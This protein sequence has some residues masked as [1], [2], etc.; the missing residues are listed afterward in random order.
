MLLSFAVFC[1]IVVVL[2]WGIQYFLFHSPVPM[3]ATLDVA[4]GTATVIGSDLVQQAERGSRDISDGGVVTTDP[5]SQASISVIDFQ[6]SNQ[7]IATITVKNGS[8]L[9]LEQDS[10]PRFD[11]SRDPYWIDMDQAYGSFDVYVPENLDRPILISLETTLGAS[12]RLTASGRYTIVAAGNQV[13]VVNYSGSALLIAP[14]LHNQLIAA[15]QT[16]SIQSGTAANQFTLVPASTNPLGDSGFAPSNVLDMNTPASSDGQVWRCFS[17]VADPNEAAGTFGVTDV[18]GRPAV[19]LF[20]DSGAVSHGATTC[21]QG[22][23][24]SS[25][26]LDVSNYSTIT[27]RATFKIQSQSLST[28]GTLGSECP[29]ELAMD[30]VPVN[31]GQPTTWYH[32]FYAFADPTVAFP[33][34]CQSC[35]E[36]HEQINP[37][38]WYTYES[39]NLKTTFAPQS[40]PQVIINLRFYASGHEYDVYVRNVELRLSP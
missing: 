37:G 39:A 10:R 33:L 27:I 8:S 40:V 18:D 34:I 26:G 23:G 30:Y 3:Q 15:G 7:L 14:D 4:R 20:R 13:Q 12:A 36:Q 5:Q 35:I 11:W 6:Q 9:D 19:R 25:S 16:G 29:F 38:V 2:I 21:L 28:C 17:S 24:M 32:G 1:L 22:L 31:G